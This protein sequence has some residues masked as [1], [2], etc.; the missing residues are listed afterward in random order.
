MESYEKL[1]KEAYKKVKPI[2]QS[3]ERFEIPKAT[4]KIEGNKTIINNFTQIASI[5]RRNIDHL[6]KFLLKELAAPGYQ[7][8]ERLII[9]TKI[10]G[11][12]INEKIEQYAKEFVLCNQ[13]HKPDT[14]IVTED[15]ISKMHCLA[16]GAKH[17]VRSKI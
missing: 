13:C 9:N 10:S 5:L 16:C 4:G 6:Q 14:E 17:P 8:G 12:K 7:D 2:Q 15:G 3:K 11:Q 1:L